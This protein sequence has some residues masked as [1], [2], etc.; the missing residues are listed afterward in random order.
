VI[1]EI[2]RDGASNRNIDKRRKGMLHMKKKK[3]LLL[4]LPDER[5]C[6]Q[7]EETC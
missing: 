7:P 1:E 2:V 5:L 6:R 4:T 3:E